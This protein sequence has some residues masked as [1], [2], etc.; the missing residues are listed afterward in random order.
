MDSLTNKFAQLNDGNKGRKKFGTSSKITN[1]LRRAVRN[2]YLWVH[3]TPSDLLKL[4]E[5]DFNRNYLP[6]RGNRVVK[7]DYNLLDVLSLLK[8]FET[9]RKDDRT[10]RRLKEIPIFAKPDNERIEKSKCQLVEEFPWHHGKSN[11]EEMLNKY[12]ESREIDYD[13]DI[14]SDYAPFSI[15]RSFMRC[16]S[17]LLSI[18]ET[19]SLNNINEKLYKKLTNIALKRLDP[20]G[21]Y[22]FI[23]H[24]KIRGVR[25]PEEFNDLLCWRSS[26]KCR[27]Q[28]ERQQ[29]LNQWYLG[30]PTTQTV[31]LQQMFIQEHEYRLALM[32]S[33]SKV[34]RYPAGFSSVEFLPIVV[35][36]KTWKYGIYD[37]MT[38][39]ERFRDHSNLTIS[40]E[41]KGEPTM[42][43]IKKALKETSSEIIQD[44]IPEFKEAVS[45]ALKSPE[46]KT[47][48]SEFLTEALE[49]TIQNLESRATSVSDNT[50]DKVRKTIQPIIDQ[51]FSF[52]SSLNGLVD[53]FKSMLDQAI[54]AFPKEMFGT[55]N[56]LK[57]DSET[58]FQI[59]K[60]YI[61]Y[62]NIESRPL[63]M[64]IVYLVLRDLG[65]LP[66]IHK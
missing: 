32:S 37:Q 54:S 38:P 60:Y 11:H 42:F 46:M 13:V 36:C 20:Y 35:F 63:K 49:P 31:A 48:V 50:L 25:Y 4:F 12:F 58:L 44:S 51:S 23:L 14:Q 64:I 62:I 47:A 3:H 52:F 17:E 40:H 16:I 57:L 10:G 1:E 27:T 66:W 33:E 34:V 2:S 61:L 29:L 22:M 39:T 41:L 30:V 24:L 65:L 28:L 55:T 45:E 26:W 56:G 21:V 18:L 15:G 8:T 59:L 53:F 19:T 7:F 6:I 43:T 9:T 5:Y